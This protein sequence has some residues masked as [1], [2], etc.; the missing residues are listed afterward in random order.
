MRVHAKRRSVLTITLLLSLALGGG[1]WAS[2]WGEISLDFGTDL[3]S[4]TTINNIHEYIQISLNP[5]IIG[6]V[7]NTRKLTD[8]SYRSDFW[9]RKSS[10]LFSINYA[11]IL[12]L[13][14]NTFLNKCKVGF[15]IKLYKK[16]V[17]VQEYPYNPIPGYGFITSN[18]ADGETA[19][20][21]LR[22]LYIIPLYFSVQV[23]P[24][25]RIPNIYSKV[26][27][28]YPLVINDLFT[29]HT[30]NTYD[31]IYEYRREGKIYFGL[32]LGNEFK[33]TE[34]V[35]IPLSLFYDYVEYKT[36]CSEKGNGH[37]HLRILEFT[38]TDH[39]IG[40]KTGIKFKL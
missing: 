36:V 26:N 10:Y 15:G 8:T 4:R 27:I 19:T 30:D 9:Q 18:L 37:S 29:S 17:E 23:N 38:N 22:D 5:N 34:K 6:S 12:S 16:S 32:E 33:L 1:V 11:H 40:I 2:N 25:N 35:S 7:G 13:R 14:E 20:K 31:H 28:G 3:V 21:L 24:L 39:V